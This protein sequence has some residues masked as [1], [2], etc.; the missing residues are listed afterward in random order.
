VKHFDEMFK[1]VIT[2]IELPEHRLTFQ[3]IKVE[4]K[5]LAFQCIRFIE[6]WMIDDPNKV[7]ADWDA[8]M[9]QYDADEHAKFEIPEFVRAAVDDIKGKSRFVP[10]HLI[11][12]RV[13]EES[14]V[15][16][17]DEGYRVSGKQ[18]LPDGRI[19]WMPENAKDPKGY[20]NEVMLMNMRFMQYMESREHRFIEQVVTRQQRRADQRP[21][22]YRHYIILDR[23]ST[24]YPNAHP[25]KALLPRLKALH[26]VRGHLRRLR[27]G[28]V[29]PVRAHTRGKGDLMQV[30]DYVVR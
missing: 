28:D 13:I 18:R 1:R 2:T 3:K 17:V 19:I 11:G 4:Y 12:K 22:E 8:S 15:E 9:A 24:H 5:P 6:P 10:H 26:S 16:Q 23:K 14:I 7:V 27:S 25:M 30:K 29:I 21:A 20:G